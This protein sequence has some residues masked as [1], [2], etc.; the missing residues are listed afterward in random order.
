M[1]GVDPTSRA[2]GH[3]TGGGTCTT[4]KLH[5][6]LVVVNASC[7]VIAGRKVDISTKR[8]GIAVTIL[9][10]K[11]NTCSCVTWILKTNTMKT[12]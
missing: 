1:W 9:V 10:G 2:V 11:S 12:I 8:R 5:V 3:A 7:W 6:T 4:R